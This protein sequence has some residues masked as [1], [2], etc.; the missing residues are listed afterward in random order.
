MHDRSVPITTLR[1]AHDLNEPNCS[2]STLSTTTSGTP[3]PIALTP[4]RAPP[5]R[6]TGGIRRSYPR[7]TIASS[8][9]SVCHLKRVSKGSL[10]SIFVAA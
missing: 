3:R 4:V 2:F 5:T 8:F 1:C 7:L 10:F 9:E 6:I